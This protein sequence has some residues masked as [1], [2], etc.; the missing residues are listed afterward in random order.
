AVVMDN[1]VRIRDAELDLLNNYNAATL[2]L[3]RQGGGN[4]QDQF[5]RSGNLVLHNS[6]VIL[7]GQPVGSYTQANGS[8]VI[9][10][11]GNAG[12]HKVNQV[13]QQLA[14]KGTAEPGAIPVSW[15]FNDGNS[16]DAQGSGGAQAV[17]GHV[18]INIVA[19]SD[20]TNIIA[21]N[22]KQNILNG[23]DSNDTLTGNKGKDVLSGKLGND[24]LLGLAGND[25]LNGDDGNDYLDG[26]A[27]KNV[28]SGGAGNDIYVVGS[29][30]NK[31]LETNATDSDLVVSSSTFTLANNIE[32]LT[33]TGTA[34]LNGTGNSLGN[35]L[36]G[37]HA[38]NVLY[39]KNGNDSLYGENGNDLLSGG[40]D[41]D[42]LQGG[43]GQDKLSGGNAD[44]LLFGEADND[45]LNGD[46][47]NDQ[48]YGGSGNDKLSGGAGNDVLLGDAGND[49]LSGG[50]GSDSFLGGVGKDKLTGG[51]GPDGFY[52]NSAVETGI[53][54]TT[55]DVLTDFSRAQGDKIVLTAFDANPATSEID[56]FTFIKTGVFSA[57]ATGQLRFDAKSHVLYGSTDA[58]SD[59]EFAIQLTGVKTLAVDDFILQNV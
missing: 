14:Y 49:I 37:N 8:L 4:S 58:D 43:F 57:D 26:G 20:V 24:T 39:G 25:T 52:F 46:A 59:A 5:T 50:D 22:L 23:F 15:V 33:L 10:F 9:T 56:V 27:G 45:T 32:N 7:A 11:N 34:K 6:S 2:T 48:L 55:W 31:L 28:L 3:A 36:Y 47:G 21:P 44:D 54:K 17:T 29:K 41:N 35:T 1:N 30:S 42:K 51:K 40:N 13:L 38:N 18:S 53:D 19:G 16:G 12:T